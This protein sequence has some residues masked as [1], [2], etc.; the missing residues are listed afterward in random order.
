MPE[1]KI[2]VL[3]VIPIG[4]HEIDIEHNIFNAENEKRLTEIN[5]SWISFIDHGNLAERGLPI[6]DYYRPDLVHLAGRGVAVFT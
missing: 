4:D 2:V 6:K 5:K 1:S 3:K